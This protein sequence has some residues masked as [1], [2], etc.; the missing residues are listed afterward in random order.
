[1]ADKIMLLPLCETDGRPKA[2]HLLLCPFAGGS[3]S[4]FRSWRGLQA[5]GMSV[6]LA[7]YPGRDHRM[8]EA[9]V[10]SIPTLA[11]RVLEDIDAE[12]M[13]PRRLIVAGHSIGAQVAYE[14]CASLERRGTPARGL[15][16]SGCHAPHLRSRRLLSHLEDAA[17]IEQLRAIG[18]CSP[19]LANEPSLWP[20]FMPMLRADFQST[21][22]YWHAQAPPAGG[23]L[24][25]PA[26]LLYGSRDEEAY[27]A[28]VEAW[29]AWLGHVR[30]PLAI[31]GDHFYVIQRPRAFLAHVRGCFESD[32]MNAFAAG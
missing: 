17:F 4:A 26:L 10:A 28:E 11:A 5:T 16:I 9:C 29:E 25:T 13:D 8:G 3:V 12:G 24:Q 21:E 19:E 20:V 27:A 7:I 6:A 14:I 31:A 32:P 15:V 22:G 2:A 18:G 23:R 1:M 30:G